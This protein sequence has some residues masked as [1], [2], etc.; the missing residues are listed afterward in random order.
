MH[1]LE[2]VF[3]F[4]IKMDNWNILLTFKLMVDHPQTTASHCPA[5]V[6]CLL[7]RLS[8][9]RGRQLQNQSA[10]FDKKVLHCAWNNGSSNDTIAVGAQSAL[11]LYKV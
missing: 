10:E 2:I 7:C 1:S 11:Y 9:V 4:G 8:L 6:S 5:H 3:L